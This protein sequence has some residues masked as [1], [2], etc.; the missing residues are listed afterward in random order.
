MGH[1]DL[2]SWLK[3]DRPVGDSSERL[4]HAAKARAS[5][6]DKV[7]PKGEKAKIVASTMAWKSFLY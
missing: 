1:D 7:R 2:Q 4:W 3:G 5:G 6:K